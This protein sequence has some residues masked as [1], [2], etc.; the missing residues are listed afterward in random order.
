MYSESSG[1]WYVKIW[2]QILIICLKN[3]DKQHPLVFGIGTSII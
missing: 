2:S 1:L 3:S